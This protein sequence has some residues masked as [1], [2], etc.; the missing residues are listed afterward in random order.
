MPDTY[1]YLQC[2]GRWRQRNRR[3][4]SVIFQVTIL[5]WVTAQ[6]HS[7][8]LITTI[9]TATFLF[10]DFLHIKRNRK[11]SWW[12]LRS[13]Y[14]LKLRC[15]CC[16][17]IQGNRW[18]CSGFDCASYQNTHSNFGWYKPVKDA[19]TTIRVCS[20]VKQTFLVCGFIRRTVSSQWNGL[21]HPEYPLIRVRVHESCLFYL[22]LY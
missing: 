11:S 18:F 21:G 7:N 12:H 22:S 10:A 16:P 20:D 6:E 2:I 8:S 14:Q 19:N 4:N 3:L 1:W 15:S 9:T 13:G 17:W 5:A